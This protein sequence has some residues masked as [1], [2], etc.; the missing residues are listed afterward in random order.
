MLDPYS[1]TEYER[2]RNGGDNVNTT[3]W[4]GPLWMQWESTAA[5][6]CLKHAQSC[7]SDRPSSI[8]HSIMFLQPGYC[9]IFLQQRI[10]HSLYQMPLKLELKKSTLSVT[11]VP[12]AASP[13]STTKFIYSLCRFDQLLFSLCTTVS[14]S[15]PLTTQVLLVVYLCTL[16]VFRLSYF[17]FVLND[18]S[19]LL[20]NC[21][22]LSRVA[23][24]LL[25]SH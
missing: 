7:C 2:R 20:Y 13:S 3:N 4:P 5:L 14:I 24:P 21:Q 25:L 19:L 17:V 15:S 1:A 11:Q 6:C 18:A 12:S 9:G 23:S 10:R 8:L 16:I 22:W